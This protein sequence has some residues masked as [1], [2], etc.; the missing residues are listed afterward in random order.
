MRI[1]TGIIGFD[2]LIGGG[3]R[4]NT[5]NVVVGASGTGK[6]IFSLQYLLE[7]I[8]NGE[9]G[10]YISFDMDAKAVKILS[11]SLGWFEL[12]EAMENEQVLVT[13]SHA[14]TI[15]YL[16]E[17]I[18]SYIEENSEG[19]ARIV[20]DSF[21]PLISSLDYSSRRDI[22]W[23]FD[24]LRASG[25]SVVT[26]EEPFTNTLSRPD[27]SIPIFLSDSAVFLKNIGYGEAF[28]RT[29][30]IIKHRASWHADGVFPYRIMPGL[31]I[32]VESDLERRFIREDIEALIKSSK[33][34]SKI[35]RRLGFLSK[36]NVPVSRALIERVLGIYESENR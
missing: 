8:E 33:I 3:Y 25:T 32:V 7:G 22:G 1:K 27:V 12:V 17:D 31:G 35:K 26:V 21:T 28:S 6:T 14:E 10:I 2:T 9:K 18:I 36:K 19:N 34:D 13:R 29:L 30:Q 4:E 15:S 11:E 20:V 23:F 5:V 24:Q 16:N